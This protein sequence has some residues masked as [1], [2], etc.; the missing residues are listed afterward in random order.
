MLQ[1]RYLQGEGERLREKIRH[2]E[3]NLQASH[4]VQVHAAYCS[5]TGTCTCLLLY[6]HRYRYRYMPLTVPL[7]SGGTMPSQ[8]LLLKPG[9]VTEHCI[10]GSIKCM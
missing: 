7:P 9:A 2:L 8:G 3:R 6:C 1:V 10:N 5:V 4:Q